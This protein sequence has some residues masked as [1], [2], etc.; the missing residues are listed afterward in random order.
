VPF[1]EIEWQQKLGNEVVFRAEAAFAKPEIYAAL[2]QRGVRYAIPI[3]TNDSLERDIAEF[4]GP[5][6]GKAEPKAGALVQAF[7]PP[8]GELEY[9][10]SGG[11]EGRVPLRGTV[12][13]R[14][15]HHDQPG[16]GR[17]CSGAVLQAG[18]SGTVDQG[19]QAVKMTR[20]SCPG[21]APARCG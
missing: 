17:P 8:G 11:S 12:S 4:A 18:N 5:S 13:P 15:M 20:L 14:W 6:R 3:P 16:N 1:P 10:A 7:S 19:K 9:G 21:S 2:E